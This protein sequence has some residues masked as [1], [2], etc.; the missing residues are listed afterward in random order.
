[1][2]KISKFEKISKENYI[3]D[4]LSI[5]PEKNEDEIL[6]YYEN[7]TLP[8]RAT[9]FSAGYDFFS[10]IDFLLKKNEEIIIPTGIRVHMNNDFVL[11]LFPRSSLGIKFRLQLN[12]TVGVIDADYYYSDNE[13]H[14][15][16]KLTN[17][18]IEEKICKIKQNEAFCQGIF[19]MY[20]ITEDDCSSE[21]R[22]G[23]FGS[24]NEK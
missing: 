22:N 24:T 11:L 5:F 10:P 14:I 16:V 13:G 2:Q 19:L 15:L 18:S 1:M 3:R 20:G 9:K 6:K 7:I 4:F 23:G 17:D 8:K 12:N 21:I